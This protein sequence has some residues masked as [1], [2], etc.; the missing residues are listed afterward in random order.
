VVQAQLVAR[1]ERG[2][3][4]PAH[5]D[6][7]VAVVGEHHAHHAALEVR[8]HAALE[9]TLGVGDEQVL[10]LGGAAARA[11]LAQRQAERD[12]VHVGWL[13]AGGARLPRRG[14]GARGAWDG[15]G[16]RSRHGEGDVSLQI[17]IRHSGSSSLKQTQRDVAGRDLRRT[18]GRSSPVTAGRQRAPIARPDSPRCRF[19]RRR[20][21]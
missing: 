16:Q 18:G 11:A 17:Q 19:S 15:R 14:R 10:R 9:L 13:T 21:C 8:A 6:H 5:G 12:A 3:G 20:K 7:R 4:R 2:R 1:R